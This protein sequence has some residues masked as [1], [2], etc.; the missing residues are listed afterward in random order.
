MGKYIKFIGVRKNSL[1]VLH[2]EKQIVYYGRFY[3]IH[4]A[5]I[6]KECTK[7]EFTLDSLL[8]PP[9]VYCLA[10]N[11][12]IVRKLFSTL[13]SIIYQFFISNNIILSNDTFFIVS[14]LLICIMLLQPILIFY[15]F[16]PSFQKSNRFP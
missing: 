1:Q 14:S 5:P 16:F 11:S 13:K 7:I 3:T 8:Y 9:D 4:T 12:S 15:Q 10:S 2:L 6:I